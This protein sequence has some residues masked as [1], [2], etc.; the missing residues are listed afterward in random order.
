MEAYFEAKMRLFSEVIEPGGAA[1]VWMDDPKSDEV[2]AACAARGLTADHLGAK[3]ETLQLVEREPTQLGQTLKIEAE[4]K[5]HIVNLPLI[6]AYQ[7]ANA[8]TAAGPGDR[9][10]RRARARPRPSR[11]GCSRSAAASNGR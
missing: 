1:V 10:G 9:H 11:A 2:I 6:G 8:L 3:G 7:A 5:I 4:G